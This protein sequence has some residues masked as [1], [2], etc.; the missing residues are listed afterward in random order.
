M[1]KVIK[2]RDDLIPDPEN[3]NAGTPRGLYM[4]EHSLARYGPGRSVLADKN[5][6]MIAGNKTLEAAERLDIP[7]RVVESDGT[8]LL[9]VVRTDL[10][11]DT[12]EEAR[13]LAY[14]DNRAGEV[15]LA[16]LP[17][18]VASDIK[19]GVDLTDL[20]YPDEIEAMMEA[21]EPQ[22]PKPAVD[23]ESAAKIPPAGCTCPKCGYSWTPGE[24]LDE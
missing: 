1:P 18:Q 21:A 13:Q 12:D 5:G 2:G 8:E 9:V 3:A 20:F 10:D 24:G 4:V 7:V 17:A 6:K 11:L 15:G 16:W 19:R 23:P 22:K 14:A